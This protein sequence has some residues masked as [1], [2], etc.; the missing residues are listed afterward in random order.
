MIQSAAAP[1]TNSSPSTP[2]PD[3]PD[4]TIHQMD[5]DPPRK[6]SYKDVVMEKSQEDSACYNEDLTCDDV[7]RTTIK[8]VLEES[9]KKILHEGPWFVAGSYVS[10]RKWKPSF[11]PHLSKITSTMIW[12]RLPFLPTEFYDKLILE[13]IGKQIGCLLK[14]D[15]CT[16]ATL[17][18]RYA[19]ICVQIPM[20]TPVYTSIYI[21][22][23]SQPIYYE[24]EAILCTGCGRLG[25]VVR[26][27]DFKTLENHQ[28]TP[29][30]TS[31]QEATKVAQGE[32]WQ[33]VPFRK[34]TTK[35]KVSSLNPVS[36]IM[37]CRKILKTTIPLT[38][39]NAKGMKT[40]LI[41][42]PNLRAP[43]KLGPVLQGA[44]YPAN[45]T[46]SGQINQGSQTTSLQHQTF[47][48]T[49]YGILPTPLFS[50]KINLPGNQQ[51]KND[52]NQTDSVYGATST[53]PCTPIMVGDGSP[54]HVTNHDRRD[55]KEACR[56][57]AD[58][59]PY[60][61]L[62]VKEGINQSLAAYG[63][64]LWMSTL[65]TIGGLNHLES[66]TTK[67]LAGTMNQ[68]AQNL[69]FFPPSNPHLLL[70]GPKLL[71]LEDTSS[72]V[73]VDPPT[74]TP[75]EIWEKEK[76]LDMLRTRNK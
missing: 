47:S 42:A 15:T 54:K 69:P 48:T 76:T 75:P 33:T 19:R 73:V 14:I 72:P 26:H 9:Q 66:L 3:P 12:L 63:N 28:E 34:K 43:W 23:H 20:D 35:Q 17:R 31:E 16:S 30:K 21:G 37:R 62:L 7:C 22:N 45:M 4:L 44:H 13:K 40:L 52:Q 32:E 70:N 38:K 2:P 67:N 46:T 58:S 53:E 29:T 50:N 11:V 57:N 25:H 39:E 5:E 8:L 61:A 71:N 68:V 10:T 55:R 27:C 49:K 24:G 64:Y 60:L 74:P 59:P 41:R 36:Q 56:G 65:M 1:F 6:P 51:N 18:G